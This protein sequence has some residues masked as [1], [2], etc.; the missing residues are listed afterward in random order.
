MNGFEWLKEALKSL[1]NKSLLLFDKLV[2]GHVP[3]SSRAAKKLVQTGT[4]SVAKGVIPKRA[5][6]KGQV[7]VD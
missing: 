1:K 5:E 2:K 4:L 3:L 7:S 6:P